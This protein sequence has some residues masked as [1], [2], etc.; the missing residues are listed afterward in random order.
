MYLNNHYIHQDFTDP[1]HKAAYEKEVRELEGREGPYTRVLLYLLT[2]DPVTREHLW[3]IMDTDCHG[4]DIRSECLDA[5]WLTP[6]ARLLVA[7]AAGI[8][9]DIC[10]ERAGRGTVAPVVV[11]AMRW[12]QVL[13]TTYG[14][15]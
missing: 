3:E 12:A 7:L 6:E 10:A 1:A 8:A 11:D 14:E 5:P 2:A 15:P 4:Y 13:Y 9:G